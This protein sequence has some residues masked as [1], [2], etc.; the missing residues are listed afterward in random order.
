VPREFSKKQIVIG[1]LGVKGGAT[2]AEI[3]KATEETDRKAVSVRLR[4]S[5]SHSKRRLAA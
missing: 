3:V 4:A 2:M 1:M 5:P